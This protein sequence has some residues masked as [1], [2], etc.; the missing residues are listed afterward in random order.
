MRQKSH[1]L[2]RAPG[3]LGM[4]PD[5]PDD[6][7][8]NLPGDAEANA[9]ARTGAGRGAVALPHA[10]DHGVG[11]AQQR[12]SSA[13]AALPRL[14]HAVAAGSRVDGDPDGVPRL[15]G[16]IHSHGRQ[17]VLARLDISHC[18]RPCSHE[19]RVLGRRRRAQADRL[20]RALA[21]LPGVW[22]QPAPRPPRGQDHARA[23]AAPAGTRGA[24][25][26]DEAS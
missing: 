20:I 14:P 15:H 13:T 16:A 4:D 8:Q 19:P 5:A 9:P 26:G 6:L 18:G 1:E 21:C 17:D 7:P 11:A 3:L 12:R 25:G 22:D 2:P 23:R 24:A 10:L